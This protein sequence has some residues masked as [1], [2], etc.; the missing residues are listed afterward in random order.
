[1]FS[2]SKVVGNRLTCSCGYTQAF[3]VEEMVEPAYCE[4][5]TKFDA[6]NHDYYMVNCVSDLDDDPH[7][8]SKVYS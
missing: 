2:L 4:M 3:H 6:T 7:D 5:L 1:M 8:S